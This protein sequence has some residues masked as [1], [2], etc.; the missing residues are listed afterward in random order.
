MTGPAG[1]NLNEPL[2]FALLWTCE[3][4]L[5]TVTF[6]QVWELCGSESPRNV[7][8]EFTE[9]LFCLIT[10]KSVVLPIIH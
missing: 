8:T 9:D 6:V 2:G 1:L 3:L 4:Q 10:L 5:A 7:K